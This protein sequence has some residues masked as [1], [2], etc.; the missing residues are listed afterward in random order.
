MDPIIVFFLVLTTGGFLTGG[1]FQID[2][3]T[4]GFFLKWILVMF[5]YR[6]GH[7]LRAELIL[8]HYLC[9]TT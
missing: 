2:D 9:D 4:G 7:K 3:L 6:N 8:V 1:F 5:S